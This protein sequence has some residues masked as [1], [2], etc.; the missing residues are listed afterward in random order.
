MERIAR[1]DRLYEEENYDAA[2][3]EFLEIL[4]LLDTHPARYRVL[5]NVGKSYERLFRYEQALRFYERFLTEGGSGD[6]NA[7]EVRAK[8]AVL[9]DLLGT[10]NLTVNIEHYQVWVDDHMVGEDADTVLV[11]GGS[12]VV[13]VRAPDYTPERQEVQ[14]P[15]RAERNLT[16]EMVALAEEFE[17]LPPALFWTAGGVAILAAVGGTIFGVKALSRRNNVDALLARP[18]GGVGMV[19]AQDQDD[20]RR[21]SRNADIFFGTALLLGTTAVIFAFLTEW[22]DPESAD[23]ARLRL[24]PA[25][26]RTSA[27]LSLEGAF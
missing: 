27:G 26:D 25:L 23:A 5:Y 14:V 17:G 2:L 22:D 18:D 13:E 12:H 21:L 24:S 6:A 3:V 4:D 15:A 19:T 10:I 8:I 1:A 7:A 20:I 11:P 16:F 9:N